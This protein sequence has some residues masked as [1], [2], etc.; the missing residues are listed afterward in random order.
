LSISESRG[1]SLDAEAGKRL[2]FGLPV[3]GLRSIIE[4]HK[5]NQDGKQ[6]L[7]S[8]GSTILEPHLKYLQKG[9]A[10]VRARS[11]S[12]RVNWSMAN[13][14][15]RTLVKGRITCLIVPGLYIV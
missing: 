7:I 6:S 3:G 10:P 1:T 13:K 11:T 4:C 14:V 8:I 12:F 15:K 5:M 2:R 9:A